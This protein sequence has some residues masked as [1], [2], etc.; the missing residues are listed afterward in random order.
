MYEW[1]KNAWMNKGCK[2]EYRMYEWIKD[3]WMNIGK[4]K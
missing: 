2:D 3:A 1:I 4:N